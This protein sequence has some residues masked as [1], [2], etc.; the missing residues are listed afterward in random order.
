[1][2][3]GMDI[4]E[5]LCSLTF[6]CFK[7]KRRATPCE[8]PHGLQVALKHFLS[9]TIFVNKPILLLLKWGFVSQEENAENG[10]WQHRLTPT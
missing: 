3:V 1:M 9:P 5:T 6:C 7:A 2:L 10:G 8:V 4:Q